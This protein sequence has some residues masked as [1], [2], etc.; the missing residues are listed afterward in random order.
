MEGT[1]LTARR[2]ESTVGEHRQKA[3][4][5]PNDDM[6]YRR[7]SSMTTDG[8]IGILLAVVIPGVMAVLGGVLGA[9]SLPGEPEKRR[10]KIVLWSVIFGALF[11]F[12]VLLAGYQQV[13]ATSQQRETEQKAAQEKL[14]SE[15]E[16]KYTQGQLD[17][18]NKI[19][20]SVV[21]Q[22]GAESR[23]LEAAL[24]KGALGASVIS[25]P[26]NQV[27]AIKQLSNDD[28]Q[29]RAISMANSIREIDRE[30]RNSV[31]IPLSPNPS[32]QGSFFAAAQTAHIRANDQWG[33]IHVQC[34]VLVQEMLTRIPAGSLASTAV[35]QQQQYQIDL[36]IETGRAD[37]A[38]PL[39]MVADY[40]E[41]LARALP[42]KTSRP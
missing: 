15:G 24:V 10:K 35:Q 31:P 6:W 23:S 21:Q 41:R 36:T 38:N 20:A 4:T 19:L 18:I 5:I 16:V 22:G 29:K 42:V 39:T 8:L 3:A 11:I 26:V 2:M 9:R 1:I 17:S 32:N 28:L 25:R 40:V 37:G 12:S 30:E 13:R 33:A 14:L 7:P 34:G 27:P